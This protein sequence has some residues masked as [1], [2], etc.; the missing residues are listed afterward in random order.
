MTLMQLQRQTTLAIKSLLQVPSFCTTLVLTLAL[1]LSCFFVAL[2]LFSGFFI[3]PLDI[4]SESRF[5]V[6]EQSNIYQDR[7]FE[8]MQSVQNMLNWRQTEALYQKRALISSFSDVVENL[9]GSPKLTLSFVSDDY[10]T[11]MKMPLALGR[12]LTTTEDINQKTPEVII[13]Y[14]LWQKYFNGEARVLG[15]SL[16]IVDKLYTVVGVAAQA[17]SDPYFLNQGKGELWL[18]FSENERFFGTKRGEYHP[19]TSRQENLKLLAILTEQGTHSTLAQQLY[20]NSLRHRGEWQSAEQEL[21][22]IKPIIR[23]YRDVEVAEHDT[24]AI[25]VLLSVICLVLIA[26]F[27]VSNLFIS[28]AHTLQHQL[29]LQAMLGAKRCVLF[30]GIFLE[31]LLLVASAVVVGLFFAAWQLRL[32]QSL[33]HS[34]LPL[35]DTLSLDSTVLLSAVLI[36]LLLA[37]L[38]AF[39]TSRMVNFNQLSQSIRTSGKGSVKALSMQMTK[40]LVAVQLF[41]TTVLVLGATLVL[42]KSA[43][44]LLRPLGTQVDNMYSV[45]LHIP[46]DSTPFPKRYTHIE[47]FKQALRKIP[48]V[49]GVAHGESPL[50]ND[51]AVVAMRDLAGEWMPSMI[52][53]NVGPDY[54]ALTG[55]SLIAGR[56]FSEAAIRGDKEE[57]IVSE[58]AAHALKPGGNVLGDTFFIFNPDVPAEVVGISQNFNHPK[59]YTELQG[60]T[61]WLPALP[62]GYPFIIEMEPDVTLTRAQVQS[63]I[64]SVAGQA[65][66]WRFL[67]LTQTYHKLTYLERLTLL[68][69]FGLCGFSLLLCGVGIYGVLS[70]SFEQRRYEFGMRMALGAKKQRLYRL[71][72]SDTLIPVCAA[73]FVAVTVV[74]GLYLSAPSSEWV[75]VKPSWFL[76]V[77]MTLLTFALF[78]AVYPMRQLINSAPM[79]AIRQ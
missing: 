54:F 44:T 12:Y 36:V 9:P 47:D 19:W 53:A 52:R 7:V 31:A 15:A 22:D 67:D 39:V 10:F 26:I 69:S 45:M 75:L 63:A 14:P 79:S 58:A 70:Y 72:I 17:Y 1:T 11:M 50:Q 35:I 62:F 56:T 23:L 33:T 61:A 42:S 41:F 21:Q 40:T 28:R 76:V 43:D 25:V 18:S 13:S 6:I 51:L 30:R 5:V 20:Q 46:N 8:G 29:V 27:N 24:L 68:L 78:C 2:S 48:G 60:K 71:L 32:V 3:K 37:L 34:Y 65:G 49:V 55:L 77:L 38:F 64:Q 59:R 4:E 16:R 73:I 74:V 57:V 66:I